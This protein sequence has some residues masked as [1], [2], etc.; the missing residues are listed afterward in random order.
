MQE[1][2]R[3]KKHLERVYANVSKLKVS[4]DA[5]DIVYEIREELRE[6]YRLAGKVERD[7]SARR[8]PSATGEADGPPPLNKGGFEEENREQEVQDG[9]AED[10]V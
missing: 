10:E 4:G 9:T 2:E 8:D 7:A 1:I 6:A 5:V 3:L